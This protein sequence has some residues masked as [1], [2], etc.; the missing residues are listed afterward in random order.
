MHN[1]SVA[2]RGRLERQGADSQSM[3]DVAARIDEA[4]SQIERLDP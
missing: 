2:V 1:F 4:A 3:V